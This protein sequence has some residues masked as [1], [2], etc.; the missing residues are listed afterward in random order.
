[1]FLAKSISIRLD[2]VG[3][4]LRRKY[5]DESVRLTPENLDK[6]KVGLVVY[7]VGKF[8]KN[9]YASQA[10]A[11]RVMSGESL[12]S[13]WNKAGEL[14]QEKGTTQTRE[15]LAL[16]HKIYGRQGTVPFVIG[17]YL[18]GGPEGIKEAVKTLKTI[19]LP[20]SPDILEEN[21][22]SQFL[23][24]LEELAMKS[25]SEAFV[26]KDEVSKL[27]DD[28]L[29]S[30]F[31]L[32]SVRNH[33]KVFITDLLQAISI[34]PEE[35]RDAINSY[36]NKLAQAG[37]ED[38]Y[39][40]FQEDTFEILKVKGV[41]DVEKRNLVFDLLAPSVLILHYL[42][43][44]GGTGDVSI[45]DEWI[46]Y[47]RQGLET[48]VGLTSYYPAFRWVWLA[49]R[50]RRGEIVDAKELPEHPFYS[51]L[52]GLPNVTY[53]DKRRNM[54][55]G[56][57]LFEEIVELVGGSVPARISKELSEEFPH[58]GIATPL[59]DLHNLLSFLERR[60]KAA[61]ELVIEEKG[62][63]SLFNFL[64]KVLGDDADEKIVL[65]NEG[66]R[67]IVLS[68]DEDLKRLSSIRQE[69]D[70]LISQFRTK[71]QVGEVTYW[72]WS[73]SD[74]L[75]AFGGTILPK[76]RE[77]TNNAFVSP[78][79]F[80][81]LLYSSIIEASVFLAGSYAEK[82]DLMDGF[83]SIVFRYGGHWGRGVSGLYG[84]REVTENWQGYPLPEWKVGSRRGKKGERLREFDAHVVNLVFAMATPPPSDA[85][86]E[87]IRQHIEKILR[88]LKFLLNPQ[89]EWGGIIPYHSVFSYTSGGVQ[90]FHRFLGLS[91][92]EWRK[93]LEEWWQKLLEEKDRDELLEFFRDTFPPLVA[94]AWKA[95]AASS[96]ASLDFRIEKILTNSEAL[97]RWFRGS[98]SRRVETVSLEAGVGGEEGRPLGELIGTEEKTL[99]M[100][101]EEKCELAILKVSELYAEGK[102]EDARTILTNVAQVLTDDTDYGLLPMERVLRELVKGG[103][104]EAQKVRETLE[105]AGKSFDEFMDFVEETL[106]IKVREA[107][108]EELKAVP[109]VVSEESV[110]ETEG[111]PTEAEEV[112][113][114]EEVPEEWKE[115]GIVE[116]EGIEET[117]EKEGNKEEEGENEEGRM[118]LLKFIF[119]DEVLQFVS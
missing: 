9:L 46:E 56:V 63:P 10:A 32:P 33:I 38:F 59:S 54:G 78:Q 84:V 5:G 4:Y 72:R 100:E 7:A 40:I 11:K 113:V 81:N 65:D 24:K 37:V 117:E 57:R 45:A 49:R 21:T 48:L 35:V 62:T 94:R 119:L 64:A 68:S 92:D 31:P 86:L 87:E 70:R 16:L 104:K 66:G 2:V 14:A 115:E 101:L 18:Q 103:G 1:M 88:G 91:E 73:Y 106:G 47:G 107:K 39:S 102:T 77:I 99:L 108:K 20:H 55:P 8:L 3:Q 67:M 60:L 111:A 42:N 69:V 82:K 74:L 25:V 41:D 96:A 51:E 53:I 97:A 116:E 95:T 105:N 28:F 50:A 80:Y 90:R 27:V 19:E 43:R 44:I 110:V 89:K 79:E 17:V 58:Y 109:V 36:I 71:K 93:K 34:P 85:S 112:G 83:N 22:I 26:N 23:G 75:E 98:V 12:E 61:G 52:A 13:L 30:Y 118:L 76:L 29:A 6:W 15:F 114:E